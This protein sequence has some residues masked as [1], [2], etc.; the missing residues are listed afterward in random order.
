V[1]ALPEA[2]TQAVQ[3]TDQPVSVSL[4]NNQPLPTWIRYDAQN[5]T[6]VVNAVPASAF[7]LSIVM[8][9]GGQNTLIQVSEPKV[10]P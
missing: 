2:V 10:N 9:I 1:I 8:T 4:T 7:P 6:L 3:S 5:K